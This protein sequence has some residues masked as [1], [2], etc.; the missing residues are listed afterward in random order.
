[1]R[2][3]VDQ[4]RSPLLAQLLREAGHDA[5]HT[6]DLG[7]ER[8]EDDELIMRARDEGRVIVSGDTDFSALLALS[9]ETSPS[10][11]LFRQRFARRATQ[12]AGGL[13]SNLDEIAADL[14][15]GAI[16]VFTDSS[17]R[18]RRLPLIRS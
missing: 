5:V 4:N 13:L 17:I 16:V 8:A 12:Q 9:H 2:F 11:I 10:V 14:E 3:L 7:L 18:V 1:M 6:E 15:A